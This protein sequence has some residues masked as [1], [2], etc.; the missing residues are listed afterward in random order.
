MRVLYAPFQMGQP[1]G[2]LPLKARSESYGHGHGH[3]FNL[4]QMLSNLCD[5]DRGLPCV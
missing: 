4:C 1:S 3:P 2:G 5:L